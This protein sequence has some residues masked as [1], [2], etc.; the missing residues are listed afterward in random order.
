MR[1]RG[2]KLRQQSVPRCQTWVKRKQ[3]KKTRIDLTAEL[4]WLWQEA[5]E[6]D[7]L[8]VLLRMTTKKWNV[9]GDHHRINGRH[10]M[11]CAHICYE[12]IRVVHMIVH[13][14]V[15][16]PGQWSSFHSCFLHMILA[17]VW[18]GALSGSA[19]LGA[20]RCWARVWHFLWTH[21]VFCSVSLFLLNFLS[22]SFAFFPSRLISSI[23][24]L[25]LNP[26]HFPTAAIHSF[27][28]PCLLVQGDC[29]TREEALILGVELCDNGFMHHGTALFLCWGFQQR[30][31][32]KKRFWSCC[33]QTVESSPSLTKCLVECFGE[34]AQRAPGI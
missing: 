31:K 22:S 27:S 6:V 1:T 32:K 30:K 14:K 23:Y 13:M 17:G 11:L 25:C 12:R 34:T 21:N 29:R 4:Y 26:S 15:F 16:D 3:R 33:S 5:F 8:I 28:S 18:D 2:K 7:R 19:G 20:F 24:S 9:Y 10:H